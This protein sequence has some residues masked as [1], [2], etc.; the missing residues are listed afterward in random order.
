MFFQSS[1]IIFFILANN[2]LGLICKCGRGTFLDPFTMT[3]VVDT[4]QLGSECSFAHDQCDTGSFCSPTYF[5]C[6]QNMKYGDKCPDIIP[7]KKR[8][9]CN[10]NENLFCLNGICQSTI[11]LCASVNCGPYKICSTKTGECMGLP[12]EHACDPTNDT[13]DKSQSLFCNPFR[14]VCE[15]YRDVGEACNSKMDFCNKL[16]YLECGSRNVCISKF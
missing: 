9:L 13:C 11:N 10:K 15:R 6:M 14:E 16:Q 8:V 4:L 7:L 12:S 5:R 1:F 3:C 2:S